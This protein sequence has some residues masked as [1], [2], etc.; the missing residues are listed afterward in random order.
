MISELYN[1]LKNIADTFLP[2]GA[3]HCTGSL[4]KPVNQDKKFFEG[5]EKL[6]FK[7]VSQYSNF[8]VS[9]L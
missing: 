9:Q 1:R 2:G 7:K 6:F 4:A 3:W 8:Q 5:F